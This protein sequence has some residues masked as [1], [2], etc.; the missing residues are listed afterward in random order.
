MEP[1]KK[2]LDEVR[3][4]GQGVGKERQG[5]GGADVCVC[6]KCGYEEEHEKGKPCNEKKC[7]KCKISLKG[8]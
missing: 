7:P 5:D 2:Y 4:E 1:I 6:P 8:K 3:G